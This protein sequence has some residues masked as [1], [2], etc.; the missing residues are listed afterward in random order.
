MKDGTLMSIIEF[1][2][3]VMMVACLAG[4]FGLIY[5]LGTYYGDLCPK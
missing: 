3:L 4:L 1:V 2:T 5:S